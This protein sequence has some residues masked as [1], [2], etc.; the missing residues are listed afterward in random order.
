MSAPYYEF[1]SLTGAAGLYD[2]VMEITQQ[3][4]PQ[5]ALRAHSIKLESLVADFDREAGD[6]CR[7]L[8]LDFSPQMREF[9]ARARERGVAT[10]S[11]AQVARG[12]NAGGVG[13]WR[14]YRAQLAPVLPL[15]ERWVTR[16]GYEAA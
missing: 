16:F 8:D 12:L 9:A 10:A 13:E 1:L 15:L 14:R 6:V 4:I 11:G 2:A 5:L 7:F 3:L